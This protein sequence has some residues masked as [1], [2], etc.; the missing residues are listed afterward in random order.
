MHEGIEL[1]LLG[2]VRIRR[3]GAELALGSNRRAAVLGVLALHAGHPVARER[4]VSAVWGDDP[5]ASAAGNVYTY[6]SALRQALDPDRGPCATEP[7]LTSEGGGYRLHL[8]ERCVDVFRFE[9]LRERG[10][11][12]RVAG[13]RAGEL[14]TLHRAVRLWHG[15]ALAGVPG[16]FAASHRA[17]L[18]ELRLATVERYAAVLLECGRADDA[19]AELRA[20]VLT[21]PLRENLH[22]MLM[23][24]L[25]AAGRQAEAIDVYR[26]LE[27]LLRERTG[28][29]PGAAIRAG[30]ARIA[31]SQG[32]RPAV[33]AAVVIGRAAAGPD[34]LKGRDGLVGRDGVIDLLR[35]AA[36]GVAAGHGGSLLL[37]G[38]PG[39]GKSTLLAAALGGSVPAGCRIGW[40][41][42]DE[43]SAIPP[44]GVLA[45]C[46][47][48]VGPASV[49][50]AA[51]GLAPSTNVVARAALT[52][53]T[54]CAVAIVD[55]V[56]AVR[57]AC[58]RGP[59]ILVVDDLHGA[60]DATRRAWAA[61]HPL[62]ATQPLLLVA[63]V[64]S[65]RDR[66]DGIGGVTVIPLG[67][68]RSAEATTLVRAIAPAPPDPDVLRRIVADA[69]GNPYYLRCLAAAADRL[70]ATGG[71]ADWLTGVD[72]PAGGADGPPAELVAAID[73]HLAP[74]TDS[75]R[76]VLRAVAFLGTGCT[77]GELAR[78]TGRPID[79]LLDA[80]A[81][82]RAAGMLTGS[83]GELTIRHPVVAWVLHDGTPAALRVALHR[84]FAEKI[85]TG[86]GL[87][88]RVA[89]HLLAGPVP[90]NAAS[91]DWLLANVELLASRA[92]QAAVALLEHAQAQ[93]ELPPV[94]R[95]NAAAWQ[96]RLLSLQGLDAVPV[97]S[98]VAA[99]TT[100]PWLEAEMRWLVAIT[101]ERRGE[102]T[103]AAE[104]AHWV[105]SA[106]RAPA[107]WLE[108]FRGLLARLRPRT[109]G[110][111]TQPHTPTVE[112]P[113][114]VP[115]ACA[116]LTDR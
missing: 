67:P 116:V 60:D 8:P 79:D 12:L 16:P 62:T 1:R 32:D 7:V 46:L 74:W 24:A 10:R 96:A 63:T 65:T 49:G 66:P 53:A 69:A 114:P 47:A 45:E 4:L 15:D 68:L 91:C 97:A 87:P 61:L 104:A 54:D 34:R 99:R 84:S 51:T 102:Y 105:L 88:E 39:M 93:D 17:R 70:T 19:I 90:L 82:V 89:A 28:L 21:Y 80:L 52:G 18:T 2:P 5:P 40:A 11:Q 103:A 75:T 41:A 73:A 36:V 25:D 59:L 92:P 48:S 110:Y 81:P 23:T 108:R 56:E 27:G 14:A 112:V 83:G 95:L 85:A 77:I 76:Q 30:Y 109:A 55:A 115:A 9:E 6:V 31:A 50:R 29:E 72:S 35:R 98:W 58:A 22:G 106:R 42:G 113:R 3:G 78:V 57:R 37:E 33:P 44:L 26:Q 71:A 86:G 111:P 43:L 101:H 20:L 107:S 64:R 100:D 94:A 13:D 38:G